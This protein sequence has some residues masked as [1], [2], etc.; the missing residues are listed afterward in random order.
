MKLK[1]IKRVLK[2]AVNLHEFKALGH[3]NG[4]KIIF[5]KH[6]LKTKKAKKR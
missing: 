3:L 6:C 1:K 4:E 5:C 2:C